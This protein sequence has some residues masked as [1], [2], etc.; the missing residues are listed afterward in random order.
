[1]ADKE[2]VKTDVAKERMKG[3]NIVAEIKSKEASREINKKDGT[4]TKVCKA[5][6]SDPNGELNLQLWGDE[7]E[8]VNVGDIVKIT[9]GYINEWQG[10]KSL[11]VGRFGKL[12]IPQQANA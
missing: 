1:M 3:I 2:L 9:N 6:M 8:K 5:L 11:N 10:E 4:T 12:E 7:I